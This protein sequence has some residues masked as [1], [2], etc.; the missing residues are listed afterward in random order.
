MTIA[1][2]IQPFKLGI[3]CLEATH[4]LN[5]RDVDYRNTNRNRNCLQHVPVANRLLSLGLSNFAIKETYKQGLEPLSPESN[6]SDV[7]MGF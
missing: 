7:C 4:R 2:I 3:A 1:Q 5:M 6:L